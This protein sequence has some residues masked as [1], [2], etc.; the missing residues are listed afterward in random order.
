[1]VTFFLVCIDIS[2][3]GNGNI[4]YSNHAD[5]V[6]MNGELLSVYAI[7][8]FARYTSI[9]DTFCQFILHTGCKLLCM[10]VLAG[11]G[12]KHMVGVMK[13]PN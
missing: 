7:N 1:M 9:R 6:I 12:D 5:I 11:S 4:P 8:L 13:K 10:G 3:S 2:G